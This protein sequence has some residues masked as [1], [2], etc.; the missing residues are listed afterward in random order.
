MAQFRFNALKEVLNRQPVEFVRE[1]NLVSD[2]FGM[3]VFDQ[4]KMKKYLSREAYKSVVDAIENGTT[5]DR[6]MADQV[7]QGMKAW[8]IEN[9]ATHYTHWFHPLTDGTAEK[10]DAFIVNGADGGVIESFSGKLLAQ[11]EPDASSFPSGGI[12]QTFE[13]RGYTA[14]DPTSP[15]FISETTLT[16]PTIF[17][18]YT[19]EALDFKTPLLRA[20]GTVDKA[21]TAVCQYFDKNVTHV[22]ANLGWEQEYFLIDEALYMARPDLVLTGRTLMG[23]ASS[24]D[25]QLDD[26]Y[27][28]SIPTRVN[29]FMQDVE[30]EAYKLGIPI[31]TRHNEV[32]PNQF[33][34][35]PIFEEANLSNDHNQLMMDIMQKIARRHK[36]RILFHE[37]PFSGINGSGKHN[38]WS[39]STNTGVNLYSPGKN[40]KTNLQFLTFVVNTLKAV[41][42]NQDL[43]RA[44]ILNA[45]NSHR[46]GANEAPPS[47]LSVFLGTEVSKML[48]LM[49]EAVVDR[50]MTPDEKTALKL[51]IGR[52]PE[53]ILD[54]T[55]RNRTSPFAFTGNRFEFRAVGSSANNASALIVLNT[56]VANQLIDFKKAVDKLI[57][58][59]VKKDEAIF[60]TLKGL[61]IDSKPIRFNG[62]GYSADW[63]D[64][65]KKR[66]LTNIT[67]VPDS[68]ASYLRPE[69]IALF[70]SM[71][72]FNE[73]ELH[74]R[75]EVEYEKFV[76]KIQIEARVLGDLAINHIVPT[77]VEYQTMLLENVKNLKEVFSADE[78]NSLAGARKELIKEIGEHISAIKALRKEM[79]EARKV[80]NVVED[81]K[82]KAKAYDTN[83]K[84]F[85]DEIRYHVDKLEL[86]VDNEKWPLPKYRELLFVR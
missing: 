47:I 38:N 61:I 15:A 55:D 39:L 14:W 43:L 56:V 62:D 60:Q 78:F 35:A 23:H 34:V 80:A 44:S 45:S 48:D 32:A 31:K 65:A 77:A 7:A 71:G 16:I 30:N 11:Q 27:F 68:L 1:D 57:E 33:E 49:E 42:D 17:I 73:S 82:E 84:P 21:A 28:S 74:G 12:R 66:G 5:I 51:N 52:I 19:G 8:A 58:E 10:H 41:Y 70:N 36:F 6:K 24:K 64:E 50:K 54:N 46:L 67:N 2:Y 63:V 25:Q 9:G 76:M 3:L 4:T 79:I 22:Q 83:V 59:G 81:V 85:L 53:I 37:K 20:L 72:V 13:A 86:I 26:H 69:S 29:R 40:P 18:S 75:V